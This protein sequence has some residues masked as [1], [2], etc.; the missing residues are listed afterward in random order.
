MVPGTVPRDFRPLGTSS[1]HV[2]VAE[3]GTLLVHTARDT[4]AGFY[5]CQ[6]TNGV[7]QG[8]SKVVQVKV[9]VAAH[10]KSKFAADMARRGHSVRLRCEALGDKPLSVTW[11]KDKVALSPHLDS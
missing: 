5:L 4:D 7:G 2:Q 11:L 1:S 9:H 6:A 10:F 3:N 8:L